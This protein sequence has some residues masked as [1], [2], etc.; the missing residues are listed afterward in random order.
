LE[1]QIQA[2]SINR[3]L[4]ADLLDDGSLAELL[5][6]EVI[7][8]VECELQH[9]APGY[10]AR[11]VD[12]LALILRQLGDLTTAEITE[13]CQGNGAAWIEQL[14]REG[15][16]M[17]I[18]LPARGE[19]WIATEHAARYRAAFGASEVGLESPGEVQEPSD[20][21]RENA[22]LA[23]LRHLLRV[24]GPLTM[25]AILARYPWD[26]VWLEQSLESLVSQGA[27]L[28]GALV[29]GLGS[30]Q[31][32]DRLVLE[33][34][35]RETL[36]LLRH[37]VQPVILPEYATFLARWQ[38]L[39]E[40]EPPQDR[41]LQAALARLAGLALPAEIWERDVLPL[42][43][44]GYSSAILDELCTRGELMWQAEGSDAQHARVRFFWAG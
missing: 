44:P 4:L 1:R 18:Q 39:A 35:H 6:P 13:R 22:A 26:P 3:E 17:R 40:G 14:E 8:R 21:E 16:A 36:T 41:S 28:R 25:D 37:E 20:D 9:R 5:R 34:L 31:W 12:E 15:R 42:R 24:H 2:L 43:V 38:G 19:R 27:V 10:Q 29:P 32:C 23:V 11:T 33:R 30:V 7:E